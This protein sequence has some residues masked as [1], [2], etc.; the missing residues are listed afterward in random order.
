MGLVSLSD[1]LH[2]AIRVI[3]ARRGKKD[4]MKAILDESVQMWLEKN[5]EEVA[6]SLTVKNN[7]KSGKNQASVKVA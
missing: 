6:A 4:G 5:P 1:D 2:G 7:D 3:A